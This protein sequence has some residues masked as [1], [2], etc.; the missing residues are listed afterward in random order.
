MIKI[1]EELIDSCSLHY[2]ITDAAENIIKETFEYLSQHPSLCM[3]LA[4]WKLLKESFEGKKII[5][6]KEIDPTDFWSYSIGFCDKLYEKDQ[7][8]VAYDVPKE[9]DEVIVYYMDLPLPP[10]QEKE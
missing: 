1:P 9:L 6:W 3:E 2:G 10:T 4:G 8:Y 5:Y 7:I